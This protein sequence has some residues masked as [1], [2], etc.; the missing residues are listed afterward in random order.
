M[1]RPVEEALML[2]AHTAT[3]PVPT[4]VD[5]TVPPIVDSTLDPTSAALAETFVLW[6]ETGV[7]PEGL[8]SPTVFGDLSLPQWRVQTRGPDELYAVR[9]AGHQGPHAVRVERLDRT[10]HG[11]VLQFSER[12][13]AKGQEWYA[14]ELVLA[15]AEG[16]SI[17]ELVLY[18]T[19]DWDEAT[20]RRH[21]EQVTLIRP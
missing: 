21:A 2:S 13:A 1:A 4:D 11:F 7:R 20:Q 15:V 5:G 14:R 16:D 12:W 17:T 9:E 6:L 8:F 18:C 19:G 3:T 10:G